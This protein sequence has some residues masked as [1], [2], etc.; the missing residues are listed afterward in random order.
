MAAIVSGLT[1]HREDGTQLKALAARGEVRG[2]DSFRKRF[3]SRT[4][5]L[6]STYYGMWQQAMKPKAA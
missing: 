4:C 5:V 6:G 2:F 1:F 3:Y